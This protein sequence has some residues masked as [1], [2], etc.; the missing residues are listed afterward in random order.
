MDQEAI[1]CS[2]DARIKLGMV[3][4]WANNQYMTH[5][6]KCF[7]FLNK[8]PIIKK[9]NNGKKRNTLHKWILISTKKKGQAFV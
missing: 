1:E 6:L 4:S 9:G 3:F 2:L 5:Q 8:T 7:T